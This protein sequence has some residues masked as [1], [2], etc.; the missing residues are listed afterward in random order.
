V[1]FG[2][3]GCV[4]LIACVNLG[5]L[6]A[7]ALG[8]PAE[9]NRDTPGAGAIQAIDRAT[10]HREYLAGDDFGVVALITVGVEGLLPGWRRRIC[11]G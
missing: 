3:V 4:P 5:E 7:G 8:E 1:L 6:A 11:R 10:A 9:R 2:A